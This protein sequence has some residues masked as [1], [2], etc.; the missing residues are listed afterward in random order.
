MV[1]AGVSIGGPTVLYIIQC[2]PLTAARYRD[3][4]LRPFVVP[5]T[6]AIADS[7]VFKDDNARLHRAGLVDDM[8]EEEGIESMQWPASSPDLNP[9]EHVWNAL[10]RCIAGRTASPTTV[11]QLEIALMEEWP[12]IPQELIDHLSASMPRKCEAVLNRSRRPYTILKKRF[13]HGPRL[14]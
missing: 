13:T 1:W 4:I 8:M 5:Y 7:F 12:H 14:L 6:G 11:P 9:T 10:G 2:A 3:E